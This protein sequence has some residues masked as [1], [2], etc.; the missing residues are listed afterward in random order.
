MSVQSIISEPTEPTEESEPATALVQQSRLVVQDVQNYVSK[1]LKQ[2]LIELAAI[3]AI[4][5]GTYHKSGID[6]VAFSLAR[7]MR[8][9]GMDITL[10]ENEH[11]GNDL[12]GVLHG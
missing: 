5:S 3:C 9:L 1:H 10:F 6:E 7:R 11:W 12:Y 4:D 2:Y 8:R